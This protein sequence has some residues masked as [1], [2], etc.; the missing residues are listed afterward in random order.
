[1]KRVE[2]ININGIIFSIDDD[3]Y[4]KLGSYLEILN[5]NFEHERG[6]HDIITDIEARISELFSEREGGAVRVVTVADVLN[7]IETLGKPE[8]ITGDPETTSPQPSQPTSK[9]PRRLYRDP[10]RRYIGGVCSGIAAWLEIPPVVIS[11]A[12]IRLVFIVATFLFGT[13]V[14]IY[15]LLWIIIPKAKTTAQKLEMRGEPVTI[16][17]I[18]KNIRE[19]FSDPLLH[20]SFRDFTDEAGE[21][22]GK[23]FGTFGRLI[24]VILGLILFFCG[25]GMAIALTGLLF[26]QDI[27]FNRM[28]EWDFLSFTELFRHIISPASYVILSVCGLVAA[29]LMVFAVLFWGMQLMTGFKVKQKLLHVALAVLWISTIVTGIVVCFTQARNFA[30]SNENIVETLQI[31][32]SDTLYLALAPTKMQISNNPMEVYFDKENSCFYGKPNLHVQR[33]DD[34]QIRLRLSRKSQGE[35]KRDA[36][37]YAENIIYSV[38][39]RDSLLTFEPFFTVIPSDRWKFQRLSITLYVPAGTVIIVDNALCSDRVL[40]RRFY[41]NC[42]WV[43]K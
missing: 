26:M 29:A 39:I 5:K 7:V 41:R 14:L 37:Q 8:D 32:P 1:M 20:Q 21:F 36:Y 10:D 33:S 17:N 3:A 24:G 23:I 19:S 18:E 9:P 11:P 12:V 25:I 15:I 30:W 4:G 22:A 13:S 35:S 31:A 38:D 43:M 34:E 42:T 28:V 27:V 2:T 6:G 16:T 40:G